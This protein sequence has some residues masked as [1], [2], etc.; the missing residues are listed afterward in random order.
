MSDYCLDPELDTVTYTLKE[1][2]NG[3]AVPNII[4]QTSSP[5]GT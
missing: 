3:A 2:I 4:F 1:Y 5:A